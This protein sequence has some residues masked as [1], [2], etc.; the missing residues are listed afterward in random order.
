MKIMDKRTILSM[1]IVALMLATPFTLIQMSETSDAAAS[2]IPSASDYGYVLTYDDK[3]INIEKVES[4]SKSTK[5]YT[6][7]LSGPNKTIET[8]G[9]GESA[10]GF[11]SF[12][13]TTGRGPFNTF[14][15]AINLKADDSDY[16]ADDAAEARISTDAGKIGYILKPSDLTQTLQGTTFTTGLYN[17][18]FVIPTVYWFS[19][20]ENNK[21]YLSNTTDYFD[22][23]YVN[24][25]LK[26]WAHTAVDST[27]SVLTTGEVIYN[28]LM[29]GVYEAHYD[30]TSGKLLS[31]KGATA[32]VNKQIG[33]FRGYAQANVEATVKDTEYDKG[34]YGLWN[35]YQWTLYKMLSYTVLGTKDA[36]YVLGYGEVNVTGTYDYATGETSKAYQ[37][38]TSNT[39][40]KGTSLFIENSWGGV[41]EFVDD[42][43]T[44]N[45]VLR[46]DNELGGQ[47]LGTSYQTDVTGAAVPSMSNTLITSTYTESQYWDLPK[48]ASGSV[49]YAT[50]DAQAQ[51]EN[52]GGWSASGDRCLLV[53]GRWANGA[54][55]GLS[56]FDSD[57]VLTCSLGNTGARLAYLRTDDTSVTFD[58]N[59]GSDAPASAKKL[60][61]SKITLET[62]TPGSDQTFYAWNTAADGTGDLYFAGDSYVVKGSDKLYALWTVTNPYKI[63]FNTDTKQ[64]TL[65]NYGTQMQLINAGV[66]EGKQ[67]V[68]W[69][70]GTTLVGN[71][72]E[73]FVPQ[74]NMTLYARYVDSYY[75]V[76]YNI[77]DSSTKYT[78]PSDIS[79]SF[80]DIIHP[81]STGLLSVNRNISGIL[82][83]PSISV[84]SLTKLNDTTWSFSGVTADAVIT[85]TVSDT[86]SRG[87]VVAVE[88]IDNSGDDATA[89]VTAVAGEGQTL[90]GK[91]TIS[92]VAYA[93][94]G[95]V[96]V[97][98]LFSQE[99]DI[100]GTPESVTNTFTVT[101]KDIYSMKATCNGTTS[102]TV[103]E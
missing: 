46:L 62:A 88:S 10:S 31:Q 41:W 8:T 49:T 56:A 63:V 36:Q 13:D 6:T 34:S 12:S 27:S 74:S 91:L 103:L 89:K 67:F 70:S 40:A 55:C 22:D 14:Y 82:V 3:N 30:S 80:T 98:S 25:N 50:T 101:G 64:T 18:M 86:T 43:M 71:F 7:E 99:Y 81:G 4:Y 1:A 92:G 51:K 26:A 9:T 45:Y 28:Y 53:G 65:T 5:A 96:T 42:T 66:V 90:S 20:G 100:T 23:S 79:V 38:D 77:V 58:K 11:W 93:I 21:L 95:G 15:A 47:T 57:S 17:V 72:G 84:G 44:N 85:L 102:L 68:G 39:G 19:D 29:L 35:F 61:G 78:S 60:V 33:D 87:T 94:E 24:G 73:Y 16:D 97:Y 2:S 37:G 75:D 59:G 76:S 69:Y 83:T 48:T 32:T 54:T 52:D